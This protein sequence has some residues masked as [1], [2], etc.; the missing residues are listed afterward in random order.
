MGNQ[1]EEK[2]ENGEAER[3]NRSTV[4]ATEEAET[5]RRE[6]KNRGPSSRKA[7]R[8][9]RKKAEGDLEKTESESTR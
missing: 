3:K 6:R 8:S 9:G 7:H 2:V 1:A 4:K 5:G